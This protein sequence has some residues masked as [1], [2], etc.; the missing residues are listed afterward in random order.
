MDGKGRREKGWDR[1]LSGVMRRGWGR[2]GKGRNGRGEGGDGVMG[3]VRK[4]WLMGES[5]AE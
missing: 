3:F 4:G 5:G 2:E 1:G